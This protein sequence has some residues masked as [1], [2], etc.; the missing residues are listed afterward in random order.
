MLCAANNN[1]KL[2]CLL[3]CLLRVYFPSQNDVIWTLR[4]YDVIFMRFKF[5]IKTPPLRVSMFEKLCLIPLKTLRLLRL[6][7]I[8][9]YTPFPYNKSMNQFSVPII[10][11]HNAI[12]KFIK[13]L[14]ALGI[15]CKDSA[16]NGFLAIINH[17]GTLDNS[18]TQTIANVNNGND[19][20]TDLTSSFPRVHV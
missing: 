8:V 5:V 16:S 11:Y 7:E 3:L 14:S 9:E 20:F 2:K 18:R 6:V 15:K 17:R 13:K 1:I 12:R 19:Q 4:S 10:N